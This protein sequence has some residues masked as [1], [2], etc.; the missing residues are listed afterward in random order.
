MKLKLLFLIAMI[1]ALIFT[2][3]ESENIGGGGVNGISINTL[4]CAGATFS[5]TANATVA[6]NG[7]AAVGYT[8][9]NGTAYA[10]G[11]PVSSTGVAGLTATLNAGTLANGN[12]ALFYTIS[13]TAPVAGNA[14]FLLVFGGVSCTMVLVVH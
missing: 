8:G 1:S 3:C 9:G 5:A 14:S 13:G 10:N 4:D 11:S 6:Y 12:G 2:S 7:I